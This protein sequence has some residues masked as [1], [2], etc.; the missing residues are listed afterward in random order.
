M[1][2]KAIDQIPI[3]DGSTLKGLVTIDIVNENSDRKD[4]KIKNV[5]NPKPPLIDTS[6]PANALS[7]LI[8]IS[9]CALVEKNSKI[10]GIITSADLLKT[11]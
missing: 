5:M 6:E 7:Q 10:I 2:E 3:F 11:M 9:G 8:R 1:H 4:I